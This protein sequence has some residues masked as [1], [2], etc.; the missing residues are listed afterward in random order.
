MKHLLYIIL[1][2]PLISLAQIHSGTITY[3]ITVNKQDDSSYK[4]KEGVKETMMLVSKAA[5]NVNYKLQFN[6]AYAK[7]NVDNRLAIKDGDLEELAIIISGNNGTYYTSLPQKKQII[8]T[9]AGIH[10]DAPIENENWKLTK[11]T[12]K[13]GD[14]LCYKATLAKTGS[15]RSLIAWYTPEIPFAY[16]PNNFI[17]KLP[18][19]ILEVKTSMT[20]YKAKEIKLNPKKEIVIKWPK[21][22]KNMTVSEYK[23]AGDKLYQDLKDER[24]R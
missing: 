16:G 12:K 15:K 4:G 22:K 2:L 7:F 1:L 11:E 17:G 20:T 19:L 10:I 6:A 8:K 23:K 24:K 9:D 21:E 13:I 3:G 18:G 5:E 14:F